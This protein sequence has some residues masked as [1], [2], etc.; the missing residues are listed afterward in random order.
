MEYGKKYPMVAA[1]GYELYEASVAKASNGYVE[2]TGMMV[3]G[4]AEDIGEAT[5][6]TKEENIVAFSKIPATD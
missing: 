2:V 1:G 5:L 4:D 3:D 6:L